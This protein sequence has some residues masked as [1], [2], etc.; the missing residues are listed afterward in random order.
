MIEIKN[1]SLDLGEF[2]LRD[3]NLTINDGEYFIILGL[4]GAV[5]TVLLECIA[6]LHRIKKGEIWLEQ[7]DITRL[8]P[9]ERSIGYVPQDYVLF[10]FINVVANIAFGLKHTKCTQAEISER[11]KKLASMMGISHL[12]YR[13]TRSLS[14]GE[15][16]RVALARA[17]APSPRVLLL[18]EPLS[19]L[20]SRT[21]KYLRLELRRV[22]KDMGI[23]TIHITHE[24]M[25]AVE[26]G[27]KVDI[28]HN[29]NLEQVSEPE[30]VL[31]YPESEK[32]SDFLGAPNILDCDYCQNLGHGVMEVACSGLKL[33]VPH[34]GN[35]VQKVTILPRDIYI[36]E[37]RPLGPGVNCFRGTITDI[38]PTSNTVKIGIEV[39]KNNLMAEIPK[40]IFKE[41]NMVAGKEIFIIL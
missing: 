8:T 36:S 12:L 21:A 30:R 20:D 41:M 22:H 24:L 13:D 26:M 11:V 18:D 9:E 25:E 14:G 15:K 19:A 34:E 17:L 23:T 3:I 7:K 33:V 39:D 6:G 28:I 35:S 27:D 2:A 31:F 16:Q 29:G 32:I 4:T 5:K 37:T 10:P 38:K 40:H 1:L